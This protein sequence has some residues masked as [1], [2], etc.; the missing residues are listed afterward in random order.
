MKSKAKENPGQ[1]VFRHECFK[2]KKGMKKP[3]I[4]SGKNGLQV[5]SLCGGNVEGTITFFKKDKIE[6][7]DRC[8]GEDWMTY[9]EWKRLK[10]GLE[11]EK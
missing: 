5:C 4:I 6:K 1:I 8:I 7:I 11:G 9:N 2:W 3:K 10:K